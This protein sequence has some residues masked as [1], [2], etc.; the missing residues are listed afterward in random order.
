MIAGSMWQKAFG[1]AAVCVLCFALGACALGN[2]PSD[3]SGA[4]SR[5][6]TLDPADPVQIELWTYYTGA[7]QRAFEASLEEFN[8]TRGKDVGV[9]A[10]HMSQGSV[11]DLSAAVIDAAQGRVGAD[12]MPDAFLSYPDTALVVD[13]LGLVADLSGYFSDEEQA[14]FVDAFLAEGDLDGNGSIKL[15][16]VGKS[17]ETLQINMTDWQKFAEATGADLDDLRTVEG[18]TATAE[19]YYRWTDARTPDIADDGLPFFGR[20]ALASYL[21]AGSRQLGHDILTVSDGKMEMTID[22]ETIR[23]LWDNYYV[24]LMNGH[25]SD[26]ERFRSDAVKTGGLIC[27]V[28]STSSAVYFPASVTVDDSSSYPIEFGSLP[29]PVFEHGVP[30][31]MQQGAGFAVAKS[32]DRSEQA[33]VEFLKWLTAREHNTAFAM[34]SGYVPV[35]KDALTFENIG[36]A[37]A[38]GSP[39]PVTYLANLPATLETIEAGTSMSVASKNGLKARAVL[40]QSLREWVAADQDLVSQAVAA[41]IPR[42]KAAAALTTD[43]NFEA[44]LATLK[45]EL[46][47][48]LDR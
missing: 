36:A 32:D 24:P 29:A 31:T 8:A 25:F 38:G 27:F 28:G 35:T 1:T 17:I 5:E 6:V 41:G 18:I 4:S 22:E 39:A 14:A 30:C 13:G 44:W 37:A 10:V 15:V 20:D 48:A 3:G 40:S 33:C 16:P 12:E 7:Q 2:W 21:R 34:A 23:T 47:T 45:S 26:E 11:S 43:E 19:R 9:V 42:E 46:Q